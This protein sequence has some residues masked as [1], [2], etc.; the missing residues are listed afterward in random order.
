MERWPNLEKLQRAKPTTIERFFID[1]NSRDPDRI[2]ERLQQRRKAVSATTDAAVITSSN[3]AI[4]AWAG[5]LKQ[6][7]DG[8]HRLR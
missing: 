6:V 1:H 5:L 7:L 8:Y 4:V 2:N 3:A